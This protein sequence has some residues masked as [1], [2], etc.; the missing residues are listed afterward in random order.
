MTAPL[1]ASPGA[2]LVR[3]IVG[4]L[5]PEGRARARAAG[6]YGPGRKTVGPHRP[7]I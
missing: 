6:H 4:V 7:C 1:E 3:P 5:G 2:V